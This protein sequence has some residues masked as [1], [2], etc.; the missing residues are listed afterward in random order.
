MNP[1]QTARRVNKKRK[2]ETSLLLLLSDIHG[3]WER[4]SMLDRDS[5]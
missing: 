4:A 1:I 3:N 5:K 2:Y